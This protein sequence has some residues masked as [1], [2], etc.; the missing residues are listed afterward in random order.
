MDRTHSLWFEDA[1]NSGYPTLQGDLQVDAIVIGAG[2]AGICAAYQLEQDGMRVAI[3]E[4][5]QV[6]AGVTAYTTAKVTSGHGVIY[7]KLDKNAG[8]KYAQA[9][10]DANQWAVHW[11]D[12]LGIECDL[13]RTDM[14][15]FA[16]T[17]EQLASVQNELEVA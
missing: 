8:R 6:C 5:N 7:S 16:D 17:E 13:Y 3:L 4:A 11:I 15:V 12:S 14:Q 9:Y 1:D 10:A 2:I